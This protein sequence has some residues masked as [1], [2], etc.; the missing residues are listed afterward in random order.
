[1]IVRV[2]LA[3]IELQNFQQNIPYKCRSHK[4]AMLQGLIA[5]M[6]EIIQDQPREF[7]FGMDVYSSPNRQPGERVDSTFSAGASPRFRRLSK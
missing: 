6:R 4:P 3:V 2:A 7:E 5:A 1:M